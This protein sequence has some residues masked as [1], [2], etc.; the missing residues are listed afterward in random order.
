M[1]FDPISALLS[2]GGGGAASTAA[3]ATAAASTAAATGATVGS[4]IQTLGTIF[5]VGGALAQGIAGR[6]AAKANAAAISQQM[7][8]EARLTAI[9]DQRRSAQFAT[10]IAQQRADLAAR[11]ISLD[12]VSAIM[13]GQTAARERSFESQAVR[14]GGAA[15]Q[16]ELS[17]E[18]RAQLA[19]GSLSMIK[20]V[21]SA[22]GSFLKAAPDIWPGFMD[23]RVGGGVL[24]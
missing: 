12:S 21:S 4:T 24:A 16:A 22:A 15:R 5:S 18:R 20:G 2:L 11:G 6:N 1:C 19:Q 17:N 23:K 3:G 9:E 8:T 14:S 7:D 13:L 10:Q